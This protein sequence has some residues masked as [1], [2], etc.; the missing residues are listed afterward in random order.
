LYKKQPNSEK[1][2]N[3]KEIY[4]NGVNY[5]YVDQG[6]PSNQTI[7]FLHGFPEFWYSWRFQLAHFSKSYRV[8][9]IDMKGYGESDKPQNLSA[10]STESLIQDTAD[11]IVELQK[12]STASNKKVILVAHDWGG[13]ISWGLA[14]VL[15]QKL[16]DR[17]VILNSPHPIAFLKNA[18]FGQ[19][20]A[21]LY[22]FFFGLPYYPELLLSRRNYGIIKR[23]FQGKLGMV[24]RER[25]TEEDEQMFVWAFSRPGAATA[26]LNYYRNLIRGSQVDLSA[27]VECQP[28]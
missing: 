15:G 8:I 1:E 21:S 28:W 26:L 17:L 5:H 6:D 27:K 25:M 7:L 22:M 11:L 24:H 4:V 10:Y 2:W 18:T 12:T 14:I 19:L 23:C 3:H 9:A 16:L 20:F 13:I